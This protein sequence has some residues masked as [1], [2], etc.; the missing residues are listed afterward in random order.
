MRRHSFS[1]FTNRPASPTGTR[2]EPSELLLRGQHPVLVGTRATREGSGGGQRRSGSVTEGL[3][4]VNTERGA[5]GASVASSDAAE[6]SEVSGPRLPQ[7]Q[8]QPR[9]RQQQELQQEQQQQRQRRQGLEGT[10]SARNGVKNNDHN[11]KWEVEEE[12]F[13]GGALDIA[14]EI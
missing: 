11:K 10:Y 8:Q 4:M 13:I 6:G 14:F 3:M 7:Q 12:V 5:S 1:Y 2:N 9:Q